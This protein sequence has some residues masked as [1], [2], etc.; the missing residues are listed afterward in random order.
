MLVVGLCGAALLEVVDPLLD[1]TE[2]I[3]GRPLV[4]LELL[5]LHAV[6]S[7]LVVMSLQGSLDLDHL[8][9]EALD[10]PEE[11][12]E[13]FRGDARRH[14]SRH[15]RHAT[16]AALTALVADPAEPLLAITILANR[17]P[18]GEAELLGTLGGAVLAN[19]PPG[20]ATPGFRLG[21]L[22][23]LARREIALAAIEARA[24]LLDAHGPSGLGEGLREASEL[25]PVDPENLHLDHRF[26]VLVPVGLVARTEH[27]GLV[28][29]PETVEGVTLHG[30]GKVDETHAVRRLDHEVH[31]RR[32]RHRS[33]E[34]EDEGDEREDDDLPHVTSPPPHG[35]SPGRVR[36]CRVRPGLSPRPVWI[37]S[38]P[39]SALP[40]WPAR[41][42]FR[43]ASY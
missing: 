42:S 41:L 15:Q 2:S 18:S 5:D 39:A 29:L 37:R 24:H 38:S 8:P 25:T 32:G 16:A 12:L 23:S 7:Q 33:D 34:R 22:G 36:T 14:L 13:A 10:A 17:V 43:P 11:I 28:R 26:A 21:G 30:V 3:V 35:S 4:D 27:D 9:L 31:R 6:T 20:L 1:L 40:P 19:L